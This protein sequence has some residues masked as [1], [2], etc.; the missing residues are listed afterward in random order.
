M[1]GH[2]DFMI[3][4]ARLS[5]IEF[6]RDSHVNVPRLRK[7]AERLIFECRSLT[8]AGKGSRFF[9]HGQFLIVPF[10]TGVS[11]SGFAS[12]IEAPILPN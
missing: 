9:N 3:Q 2:G 6:K 10:Q 4:K 8:N 12:P 7:L 5:S 11:C 1:S